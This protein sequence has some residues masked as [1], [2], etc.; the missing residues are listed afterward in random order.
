MIVDFH[1]HIFPPVVRDGRDAFVAADPTFRELYASPKARIACAEDLLASMDAGGIDISV[2]LGFAWA[3]EETCRRH[4]DY[5]LEVAAASRG[6]IVPFCSLP[7]A[8]GVTAVEREAARCVAA[9]AAGFGELR[10]DSAGVAV[11]RELGNVLT[12]SGRPLLFHVS[13]PLG[14]AYAGKEGFRLEEFLRFLQQ[15]PGVDCIGAHWG[16]GLPFFKHMPEV[17]AALENCHF[18]TAATSLLYDDGVYQAV[19]GFVGAE[20]VLF[21]SDFPLLG[22]ARSRARI[23]AA[24]LQQTDVALVLGGNAVALLGIT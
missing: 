16:G 21:G 24:G 23:E 8:A 5:L 3:A 12:A 6:R 17:A 13:E 1:T 11:D 14:H 7:L 2:A 15:H 22:Q 19:A 10:P 20:R 4:N 9:G 18:D